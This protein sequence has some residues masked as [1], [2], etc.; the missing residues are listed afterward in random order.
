MTRSAE[1]LVK[2]FTSDVRLRRRFLNGPVLR[3]HGDTKRNGCRC[4]FRSGMLALHLRTGRLP[5]FRDK[6]HYVT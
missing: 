4:A 6:I 5:T 3:S 1:L 2:V